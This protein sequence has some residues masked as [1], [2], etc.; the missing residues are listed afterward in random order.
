MLKTIHKSLL[1][2][3]FT[4]LAASC[5]SIKYTEKFTFFQM[6]DT[7]FGF[8][9]ENKEFSR[10]TRNFE[11]AIAETNRLKPAFIIVCGDLVNKPGDL[12]QIN[13]YKRIAATLDPAIKIYNV[14]GNHDV[15]NIPTP[16]S[17][18]FYQEHFGPDR[19]TFRSGN[20]FGIV[21]NSS[22]IK[23]PS[24][25]PA[26]ATEQEAWVRT[27]LEDGKNSGSRNIMI[28]MHHP[29]FLNSADEPNEYFNIDIERRKMYLELFEKYKVRQIF[30]GHYHRNAGGRAG[31]IE[32]ITTGPV[33]RPLGS[34]SS[35]FRIVDVNGTAVTHKYYPL[36]AMPTRLNLK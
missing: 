13:E 1:I 19:Y 7:Q 6:A 21:L 2:T 9:N 18:R 29:F 22:L 12:A 32:M 17:V 11:K 4:L 8:F 10:E 23:D 35:G 25:A 33:G 24:K 36:D 28:F 5:A 27:A 14:S 20:I 15:E 30:A 34:D 3:A 31:N 16:A 26:E